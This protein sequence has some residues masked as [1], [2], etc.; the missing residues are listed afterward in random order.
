MIQMHKPEAR[1]QTIFNKYL[2]EAKMF[3]F[4]ELKQ[5]DK[6]YFPLAKI[7]PHQYEG[8]QAT[9][10]SGLVWKLSDQDMRQKPCDTLCIPPLSSYIVIK[11]PYAYYIIRIGEIVKLRDSGA[12]SITLEH[13]KKV[14]EKI[15]VL[16]KLTPTETL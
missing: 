6:K 5:T 1:W 11:F 2:R 10:K 8:L 3:G 7:E 12:V 13:A 15:V 16:D 4:F 9:E 14:A